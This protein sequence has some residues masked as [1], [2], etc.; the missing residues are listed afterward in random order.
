MLSSKAH[1]K[2]VEESSCKICLG[3]VIILAKVGSAKVKMS[4]II[5]VIFA[6]ILLSYQAKILGRDKIA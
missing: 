1:H 6:K 2:I 5:L 3:E 4:A